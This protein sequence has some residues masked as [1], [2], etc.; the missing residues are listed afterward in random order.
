MKRFSNLLSFSAVFLTI[1]TLAGCGKQEPADE[2]ERIRAAKHLFIAVQPVNE[3]FGFSGGTQIAGFDVELAEAIG[4]KINIPIRWAPRG[5]VEELFDT[6]SA[7]NAD[8]IIS[9]VS[10]TSARKEKFAFSEPYFQSGHILAVRKDSEKEIKGVENLTGKKLGVQGSTTGHELVTKDPRFKDATVVTYASLDTALLKLNEREV[11]A[12]LGGFP[13][14]VQNVDKTFPNLMVIGKPLDNE[15]K[16]VV[17]RKG[18]DKLLQIVNET[19]LELKSTGKLDEMGR[20]W[21]H[22]YDRIKT[23][24]GQVP[25]KPIG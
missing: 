3:P 2:L 5:L 23:L 25:G 7:K 4:H 20:K 1:L 22:N 8:M 6:L 12:V 16:A 19:I 24:Q 11:D 15:L 14:L 21:F 18:E 9:V 17:L 10:I 13:I